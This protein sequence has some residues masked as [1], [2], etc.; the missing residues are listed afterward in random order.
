MFRRWA[1]AYSQV[2]MCHLRDDH[3]PAEELK[4][5]AVEKEQ[6][7][8]LGITTRAA[9]CKCSRLGMLLEGFI[10]LCL[11]CHPSCHHWCVM[12][13]C[14]ACCLHFV[15]IS[16]FHVL[17]RRIMVTCMRRP[18]C[19]GESCHVWLQKQHNVADGRIR[20]NFCCA[21]CHCCT[22]SLGCIGLTC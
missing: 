22:S 16:G 3:D 1:A 19:H 20:C 7:T 15:V 6:E 11:C 12:F 9:I 13:D 8:P 4:V 2:L 5:T 14:V 10:Q 18:C 17:L 21:F